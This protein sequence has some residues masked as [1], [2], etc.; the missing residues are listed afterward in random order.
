LFVLRYAK[1]EGLGGDVQLINNLG[2]LRGAL[3]RRHQPPQPEGSLKQKLAP[4][5]SLACMKQLKTPR[6]THSQRPRIFSVE[7]LQIASAAC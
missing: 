4:T 5:S 7:R 1:V 6:K 3:H 2:H